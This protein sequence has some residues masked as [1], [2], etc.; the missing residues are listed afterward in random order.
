MSN[1]IS[2]RP[3]MQQ[4]RDAVIGLLQS[5]K[6]PVEDLPDD[7]KNFFAATDNDF[8]VGAIGLEIYGS[9]GLLRSLV[10]RPGY[11]KME[12]AAALIGELETMARKAGLQ[13]VYLLTETAEGYFSKKGYKAVSRNDAPLSLQQ[14][15]E[16]THVCPSSAVL[17][18]KDL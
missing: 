10:V 15:S 13:S 3:L 18:Q 14:S 12:V 2:I 5:E 4:N 6:L 11:R 8:I 17:M 16:F 1:Q 7:L 9:H